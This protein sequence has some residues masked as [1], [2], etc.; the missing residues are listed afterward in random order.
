MRRQVESHTFAGMETA[1]AGQA[2]AAAEYTAEELT[3]KLIEASAQHQR[4]SGENRE[5]LPAILRNDTTRRCSRRVERWN[6]D[7]RHG[8][9]YE[10]TAARSR[11]A[12]EIARARRSTA[13]ADRRTRMSRGR[14]A[15]KT[16]DEPIGVS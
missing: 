9:G 3:A 15:S 6:T 16:L 13:W 2:T 7:D 10:A 1:V 11:S 12:G 14:S 4:R 8:D 5:R